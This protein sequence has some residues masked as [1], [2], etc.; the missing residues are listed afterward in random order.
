MEMTTASFHTTRVSFN[1]YFLL[2]VVKQA[3]AEEGIEVKAVYMHTALLRELFCVYITT[4]NHQPMA[5]ICQTPHCSTDSFTVV[6]IPRL[7]I[8]GTM[9][10]QLCIFL[11]LDQFSEQELIQMICPLRP[12]GSIL[13]AIWG[14]LI[15]VYLSIF[16]CFVGILHRT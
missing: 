11:P 10:G 16:I 3:D 2:Y 1:F 15:F 13:W 7:T 12:W 9:K 8:L 5:L 14:A 4:T 6:K